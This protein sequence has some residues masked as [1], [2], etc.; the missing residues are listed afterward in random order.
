MKGGGARGRPQRIAV[1]RLE[2]PWTR[3][4]VS[5]STNLRRILGHTPYQIL[6][7]ERRRRPHTVPIATVGTK[8]PSNG[9][10]EEKSSWRNQHLLLPPFV[11]PN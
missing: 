7:C 5:D 6:L 1:R 9:E 8:D 3:H 2:G 10:K 4:A 11:L